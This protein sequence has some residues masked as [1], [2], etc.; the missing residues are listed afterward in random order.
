[1]KDKNRE[2]EKVE[3]KEKIITKR[4]CKRKIT[5]YNEVDVVSADFSACLRGSPFKYGSDV[6]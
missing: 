4:L 6:V 1:M 5:K 2:K 3:E